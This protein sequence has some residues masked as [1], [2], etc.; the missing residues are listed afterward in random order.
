[1][2]CF[3]ADKS[4]RTSQGYAAFM[5]ER[6]NRTYRLDDP[7]LQGLIEKVNLKLGALEGFRAWFGLA[8]A[9]AWI[10]VLKWGKR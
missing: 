5:P 1:M 6:I 2:K 3:K 4:T 7:V 10:L 9:R 8:S